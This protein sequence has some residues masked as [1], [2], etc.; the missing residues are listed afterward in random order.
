VRTTPEPNVS[1]RRASLRQTEQAAPGSRAHNVRP[2][3]SEVK[4]AT[5]NE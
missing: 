5:E 3:G 2:L 1:G 4:E